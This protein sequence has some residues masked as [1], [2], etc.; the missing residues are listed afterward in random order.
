MFLLVRGEI[1]KY[2][3]LLD[4]LSPE[5]AQNV[6]WRNAENLYFKDWEM[7]DLPK[8]SPAYC[9]ECLDAKKGCFIQNG[10]KF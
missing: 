9:V 6:A 5:A 4:K 8:Q 3:V 2:Y 10:C 7:P 1:V